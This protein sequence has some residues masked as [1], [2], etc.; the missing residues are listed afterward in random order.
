MLV[1]LVDMTITSSEGEIVK[2]QEFLI[3]FPDQTK[4]AQSVELTESMNASLR[5]CLGK[6]RKMKGSIG[7]T[8]EGKI[9]EVNA[10]GFQI[11]NI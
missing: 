5:T 2:A 4:I 3:S 7:S 11:I 8:I 10:I 1:L 9:T 6:T